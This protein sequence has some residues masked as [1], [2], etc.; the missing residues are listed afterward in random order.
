MKQTNLIS[1]KNNFF[2]VNIHNL[3]KINKIPQNC[4]NICNICYKTYIFFFSYY[5]GQFHFEKNRVVLVTTD[6]VY[7]CYF[8]L[9][10]IIWKSKALQFF[11][12]FSFFYIHLQIQCYKCKIMVITNL[13]VG[14]KETYASTQK[15]KNHFYDVYKIQDI[16][17]GFKQYF[18]IFHYLTF[19]AVLGLYP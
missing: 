18:S 3:K 13:Y 14:F 7:S 2:H 19:K 11:H 15:K 10:F 1:K 8:I 9:I 5:I 17:Q 12:V 4:I 6:I 16:N